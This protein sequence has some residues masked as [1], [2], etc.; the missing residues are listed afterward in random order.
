MILVTGATGYTGPFVVEALLRAEEE[1]K[2]L[3]RRTSD[4]AAI[5]KTG[6]E[7]VV[8]DLEDDHSLLDA[9]DG[10]EALVAVSHIRHAPALVRAC[11]ARGVTRAVFFSSTRLTSKIPSP[12]VREVMEGE[13]A[14]TGSKLDFTLLR[15]TMIYGPGDDRNVS[16]LRRHVRTHRIIPVFGSGERPQQP[17]F[18][19]DVAQAVPQALCRASTVR[20]AYVLAGPKPIPYIG[21]IDAIAAAEGRW[22]VKVYLPVRVSAWAVGVYER[23]SSAPR[24]TAEQV[25]R[26]DETKAFDI[27]DARRDFGYDPVP[28]EEGLRLSER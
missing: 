25:R 19:R 1:V 17:V 24:I 13:A 16:R 12:T 14:V 3:V 21:L 9:L 4:A 20:K 18:V 10:A 23:S 22:V 26:F 8:G 5:R 2:A 28:F 6:P 11:A 7:I 15:P 27:S